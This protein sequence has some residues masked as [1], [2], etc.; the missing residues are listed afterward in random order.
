MV[1]LLANPRAGNGRAAAAITE[2]VGRLGA[3]GA[4][5]ELLEA[6]SAAEAQRLCEKAVAG[7]AERLIVAG[8]DGAVHVA[9]QAAA[10]TPT[11]LGLVPLGSG[12]DFAR[13]LGL[14]SHGRRPDLAVSV[15]AALAEPV[16]LDAI[17]SPAGCAASI[18]TVGFSASVNELGNRLRIPGRL[19]PARY[20]LATLLELRRLAP[21]RLELEL[22]GRAEVLEA[23]F[24]AVANTA[25]F[26]GG[27]AICPEADAAD[28]LL[29]VCVVAPVNR[30]T[31]LRLFPTVFK[32]A[33]VSHPAVSIRRAARVRIAAPSGGD[34]LGGG[35]NV[36]ADGEPYA[37]API[38]LRAAAG[39]LR[40][41]GARPGP[42]TL[43]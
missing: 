34:A 10:G 32:G 41:A 6:E 1:H 18:A 21:L 2:L 33:H 11:V 42:P 37:I 39:A 12:N 8:G 26:G 17:S 5:T 29:D 31:L 38:E 22:D 25:F 20:H 9:V 35:P 43:T 23:T 24:V 30:R 40:V 14:A 3:A 19:A 4:A 7:G 13:A 16:E 28:G 15:A 27:M 36:R